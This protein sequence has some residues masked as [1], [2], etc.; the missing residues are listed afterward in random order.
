M[1]SMMEDFIG[2]Y[3]NRL[4]VAVV[5]VGVALLILAIAL[6]LMRRRSGSAPFIRGGRNRQP[7]LQVLDATAVDARRRLVLVRR[8]N[9]EHLVMIGGPTDI[10]IESGIGAIP[11]VRDVQEPELKALPRQESEQKRAEPTIQQERRPA[12]PQQQPVAAAAPVSVP[13]EPARQPQRPEPPAPAPRP[14]PVAAAAAQVPPRP[15]TPPQP[16]STPVTAREPAPPARQAAPERE[17][18]RPTPPPIPVA[19]ATAA[20]LPMAAA[21]LDM[22]AARTEPRRAEPVAPAPAPVAPPIPAQTPVQAK[23][24][25]RTAEF[26]PPVFA[27]REPVIDQS[28]AADFL[29][30]ARERVLPDLNPGQ[31]TPPAPFPPR[32][33]NPAVASNDAEP[34]FSDELA[35]DFESFLEAE[36]AKSKEADNEPSIAP[37]AEKQAKTQPASPPVTGASPDGDMQKEMARIFGE[38]SVTRDR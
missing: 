3:G 11:I 5:G 37:A 32:P 17:T 18:V 15:S 33:E 21:S 36:I 20:V 30:A 6:W 16:V 19:A 2:T 29:D 7:R 12:L 34:K 25:E 10:V 1:I 26:A 4:I 13:E 14:A 23:A 8:D 28:I 31:T 38:L 35:S 27:A 22:A 24:E 9:V